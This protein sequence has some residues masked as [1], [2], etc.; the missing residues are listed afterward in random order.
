MV[1]LGGIDTKRVCSTEFNTM[2]HPFKHVFT[3]GALWVCLLLAAAWSPL[4]QADSA[5]D[6]RNLAQEIQEIKDQALYAGT[7]Q[8]LY[9]R[10]GNLSRNGES[11]QARKIYQYLVERHGSS[12][13]AVKASDQ[14]DAMSRTSAIENAQNNAASRA[15]CLSRQAQCAARCRSGGMSYSSAEY[16]VANQ[17][18]TCD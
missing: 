9:L 17:C 7:P 12:P 11:Y 5:S 15:S 1:C 10:A 14:L 18:G 6:W 4:A 13:F 16:C 3:Q 2:K 8:D